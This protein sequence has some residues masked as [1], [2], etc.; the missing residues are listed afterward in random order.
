M[1]RGNVITVTQRILFVSTQWQ[2]LDN[3]FRFMI[4][5]SKHISLYASK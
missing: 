3:S 5:E 2:L 1:V 4:I